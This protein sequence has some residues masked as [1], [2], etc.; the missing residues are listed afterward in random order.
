MNVCMHVSVY[1]CIVYT[2]VYACEC[3]CELYIHVCMH[4]YECGMYMC[5]YVNI[6]AWEY[7][8]PTKNRMINAYL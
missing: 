5:V 8:P 6:H 3:V 7:I 1:M 4:M 2:F